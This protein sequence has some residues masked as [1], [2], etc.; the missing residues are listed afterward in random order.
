MKSRRTSQEIA[1]KI[2]ESETYLV[3]KSPKIPKKLKNPNKNWKIRFKFFTLF[4][5]VDFIHFFYFW[6]FLKIPGII[7]DWDPRIFGKNPMGFKIPGIEIGV[8]QI[9]A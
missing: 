1:A 2:D 4:Y 7:W 3:P 5:F 6:D 8:A 9:E